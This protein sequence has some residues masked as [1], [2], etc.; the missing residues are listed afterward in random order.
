MHARTWVQGANCV[1]KDMYYRA[2]PHRQ[3]S[4][5]GARTADVVKRVEAVFDPV[6]DEE[7]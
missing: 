6:L 1:Y 2:N 3:R 5:T 7:S 4:D